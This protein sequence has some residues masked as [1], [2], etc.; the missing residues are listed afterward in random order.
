M[1]HT[2]V[3]PGI[4]IVLLLGL[5]R[6]SRG[7]SCLYPGL[8][9]NNGTVGTIWGPVMDPATIGKWFEAYVLPAQL[10]DTFPTNPLL[11]PRFQARLCAPEDVHKCM[12]Y[13]NSSNGLPESIQG[14]WWLRDIGYEAEV[15]HS[16]AGD[17]DP[18]QRKLRIYIYGERIWGFESSDSVVED[19]ALPFSGASHVNFQTSFETTLDIYMNEDYN[20]TQIV[21]GLTLQMPNTTGQHLQVPAWAFNWTGTLLPDNRWLRRSW[22]S[23]IDTPAGNYIWHQIVTGDGKPGR[24]YD[25][26]VKWRAGKP[27]AYIVKVSS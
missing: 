1:P 12:Y 23:G 26:W 3:R 13:G 15:L 6:S 27:F 14:V 25:D 17:W 8:K 4:V 7:G 21:G 20:S 10:N 11:N 5:L 22:T 19:C 18:V 9:L 24:W 16:T 2:V